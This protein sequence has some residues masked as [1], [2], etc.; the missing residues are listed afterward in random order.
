M[1]LKNNAIKIAYE[2]AGKEVEYEYLG[3]YVLDM[4]KGMPA[5]KRAESGRSN[6]SS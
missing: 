4:L 2:K 1:V 3:V 5:A 6:H